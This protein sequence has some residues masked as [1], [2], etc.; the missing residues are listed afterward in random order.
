MKYQ[1]E[2]D[3]DEVLEDDER[4][5]TPTQSNSYVIPA[6]ILVAGAMVAGAV[7][8]ANRS[9]PASA[10]RVAAVANPGSVTS[11]DIQKIAGNGP[12]LG[13]PASPVTVVE[14]GDF[15]CPYCGKFFKTAE[16]QIINQYVKTGKVKFAYRNF[17]FLGQESEWAATAA[18]C[19]GEQGK[20]WEYHNYLFAHQNGENEGAFTKDNLKH[21]ALGL[22]LD[23]TAFNSC[24]DA[25]KYLPDV[26]KDTDEGR[27][28]GVNGTPANF[29]NGQL[30][31]GAVPFEQL[32]AAIDEA[33][34]K[35]K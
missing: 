31:T 1:D 34:G 2:R 7:M 33:L 5:R 23:P 4:E 26:R 18:G 25:D 15:Q 35:T 24:L 19:A 12:F 28:F 32:A 21:F 14:F 9:N 3:E 13:N 20:F 29:I 8:Y 17:A 10:P 11:A 22:G 30:I 16:Q 27:A 6:A